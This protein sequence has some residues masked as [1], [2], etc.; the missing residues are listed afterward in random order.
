MSSPTSVP[1]PGHDDDAF[2]H[3][4]ARR[5]L[6]TGAFMLTNPVSWA[7]YWPVRAP[8]GDAPGDRHRTK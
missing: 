3:S 1:Y 2:S 7:F 8:R 5:N 6:R 4:Q